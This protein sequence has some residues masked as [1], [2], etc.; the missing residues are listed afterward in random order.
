MLDLIN[1]TAKTST[2]T[3]VVSRM[4]AMGL[5]LTPDA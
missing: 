4:P 3:F 1:L 5:S 2:L